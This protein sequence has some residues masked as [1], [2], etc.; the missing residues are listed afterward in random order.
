MNDIGI[1]TKIEK[2]VALVCIA[3]ATQSDSDCSGSCISC[4]KNITSRTVWAKFK[5]DIDIKVNDQVEID[6]P[7]G[8]IVLSAFL[9]LV[10]PL[11]LFFSFY[12]ISIKGLKI[13]KEYISALI[14]AGGLG[15][16]FLINII[17]KKINKNSQLPEIK[18]KIIE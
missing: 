2:G 11:I 3:D 12:Y 10:L 14:G 17:I 18:K 13:Q 8:K 1:I 16:G 4:G 5:T 6:Y 7:P 9:V 15:I